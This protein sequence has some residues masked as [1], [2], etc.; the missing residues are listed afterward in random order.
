MK[1]NLT[2]KLDRI[3]SIPRKF[4][5]LAIMQL[6]DNEL[7]PFSASL[8]ALQADRRGRSVF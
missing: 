8:D 6:V 5:A 4:T 2:L 7:T 3:W 1:E